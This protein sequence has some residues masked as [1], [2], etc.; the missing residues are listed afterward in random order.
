MSGDGLNPDDALSAVRRTV[1]DSGQMPADLDY[2]EQEPGDE[3]SNVGLPVLVLTPSSAVRITS[4]NTDLAGYVTDTDEDGNEVRVGRI[5]HAEYRLDIQLDIWTA[6]GS[7]YDE[8]DL[9]NTLHDVLYRHDSHGP[10]LPLLDENG[11]VIESVWRFRVEDGEQAN[12]LTQTPSLR[13]WRQDVALWAYHR[14]D[15]SEDYLA[16]VNYPDEFTADDDGTLSG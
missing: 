12:D 1:E 16:G 4:F 7:S 6:A 14:F 2:I 11:N 10:D 3:D 8:R 13:R 9:G 15:T 5:F